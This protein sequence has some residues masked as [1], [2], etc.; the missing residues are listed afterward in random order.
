MI[1]MLP[2]TRVPRCSV[3]SVSDGDAR[4]AVREGSNL[5]ETDSGTMPDFEL[6]LLTSFADDVRLW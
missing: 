1:L 2:R 5:S 3:R 6:T 4:D